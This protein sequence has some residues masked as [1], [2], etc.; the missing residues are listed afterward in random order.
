M[1]S[2]DI[3]AVRSR[4][5]IGSGIRNAI[6]LVQPVGYSSVTIRLTT[7]QHYSPVQFRLIRKTGHADI[8]AHSIFGVDCTADQRA[9]IGLSDV[10]ERAPLSRLRISQLPRHGYLGRCV[11]ISHHGLLSA[12]GRVETR[13]SQ[14]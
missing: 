9:A 8:S 11:W 2:R 1:S 13:Q 5:L 7:E 12:L 6:S 14:G 3:A 4:P 10:P